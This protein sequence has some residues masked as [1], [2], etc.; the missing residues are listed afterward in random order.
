MRHITTKQDDFIMEE[1]LVL[2]KRIKNHAD[3]GEI[4]EKIKTE[5]FATIDNAQVNS[6]IS[7]T[8]Q[9]YQELIK[10]IEQKKM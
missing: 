2:K 10:H 5:L 1:R 3:H 6:G 8:Y 9:I 4:K 7:L